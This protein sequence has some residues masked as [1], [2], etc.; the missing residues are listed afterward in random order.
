MPMQCRLVTR[1]AKKAAALVSMLG[2]TR[3]DAGNR[4]K[5]NGLRLVLDGQVDKKDPES[6][7][8]PEEEDN[9][10][11]WFTGQSFWDR[12]VHWIGCGGLDRET[13]S[14]GW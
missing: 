7:E 5:G 14:H 13:P 2:M 6:H 3:Y 4:S 10:Q 1:P 11:P 8:G 9:Q 12:E